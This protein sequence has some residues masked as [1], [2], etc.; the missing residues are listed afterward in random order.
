[1]A[2]VHEVADPFIANKRGGVGTAK[3]LQ[4]ALTALFNDKTSIRDSH[5]LTWMICLYMHAELEKNSKWSLAPLYTDHKLSSIYHF[6]YHLTSDLGNVAIMKALSQ[7]GHSP[8]MYQSEEGT[9]HYPGLSQTLWAD[10]GNAMYGHLNKELKLISDAPGIK[11]VVAGDVIE[12]AYNLYAMYAVLNIDVALLLDVDPSVLQ[13]WWAQVNLIQRDAYIET[14]AMLAGKGPSESR[15]EQVCIYVSSLTQLNATEAISVVKSKESHSAT[16]PV[17]WCRVCGQRVGK[18]GE[19]ASVGST[20][21]SLWSHAGTCMQN[22]MYTSVGDKSITPLQIPG[23]YHPNMDHLELIEA[24]ITR[25]GMLA[26]ESIT[27][28]SL[29]AYQEMI[30]FKRREYFDALHSRYNPVMLAKEQGVVSFCYPLMH[31]IATGQLFEPY[32]YHPTANGEDRRQESEYCLQALE[33]WIKLFNWKGNPKNMNMDWDGSCL[34]ADYL[35]KWD[36]T[37][38]IPDLYPEMRPEYHPT[39]F[40]I[41]SNSVRMIL[42]AKGMLPVGSYIGSPGFGL[43]HPNTITA[44]VLQNAGFV[45][46]D[47][48]VDNP[49]KFDAISLAPNFD[50]P[51]GRYRMM[52]LSG[53]ITDWEMYEAPTEEHMVYIPPEDLTAE[54]LFDFQNVPVRFAYQEHISPQLHEEAYD[55]ARKY[56]EDQLLTRHMAPMLSDM[57]SNLRAMLYQHALSR[58]GLDA[59]PLRDMLAKLDSVINHAIDHSW[60]NEVD[61]DLIKKYVGDHPS[62]AEHNSV[63][64]FR[65]LLWDVVGCEATLGEWQTFTSEEQRLLVYASFYGLRHQKGFHTRRAFG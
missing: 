60:L 33:E 13:G 29:A 3:E 51:T 1:M 6:I 52:A 27:E 15:F 32:V 56:S 18:Q 16:C 22:W 34:D 41:Q 21:Q 42:P 12:I 62:L 53:M 49:M 43:I 26:Y 10:V 35:S 38:T 11:P 2:K 4:D 25:E 17:P 19:T 50:I 45:R 20:A 54:D 64:K 48:N 40:Q 37:Y 61:Y 39:S 55:I 47:E 23:D 63:R 7:R 59:T 31:M 65:Q 58:A 36:R 28:T 46:E 24:H 57:G 9:Y 44:A 8:R 30:L 14:A 5:L